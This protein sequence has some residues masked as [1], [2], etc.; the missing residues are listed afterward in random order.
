MAHKKGVLSGDGLA[1][2]NKV[3]GVMR[4]EDF[5]LALGK[6]LPT[7]HRYFNSPVLRVNIKAACAETLEKSIEDI[8]GASPV[9]R[10]T[11][12]NKDTSWAGIGYR[13]KRARMGLGFTASEFC[14]DLGSYANRHDPFDLGN[15]SRI[16]SGKIRLPD[17][18]LYELVHRYEVNENWILTGK[19]AS[20]II[21]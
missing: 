10:K 12:P 4:L 7:V 14:E 1:L 5:A 13:V 16:E 19:G 20:G 21:I 2:Y 8:F 6:S 18:V 11:K 3:H 17:W 9:K 15:L